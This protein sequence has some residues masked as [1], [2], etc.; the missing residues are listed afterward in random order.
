MAKTIWF[1]VTA[2]S[3]WNRPP[4]GSV[5][6]ELECARHLIKE[7]KSQ[8][9]FCRYDGIEDIHIEVSYEEVENLLLR[10]DTY[11]EGLPL[12]SSAGLVQKLK[13]FIKDMVGHLPQR[14]QRII[15]QSLGRCWRTAERSKRRL[16]RLL[17]RCP[18]FFRALPGSIEPKLQR[19]DVY[20]TLG[21]D[22]EVNIFPGMNAIKKKTGINVVGICYD[23]IPIKSPHLSPLK[24]SSH[25]FSDYIIDMARCA[26]KI[27][28]ISQN[29]LRDLGQFLSTENC[30][31]PPLEVIILGGDI[32][33]DVG[34]IGGKVRT[35]C[36]TPYILFVSTI[37][38][39]KNHEILYHAYR[40]FVEADRQD[41]PKLVFVGKP[42]WKVDDFLSDLRLDRSIDGLIIMLNHVNDS[43]LSCLYRHALF[44]VYPSLYEGWGLPVAESLAYGKF[45]IA[46]NTSSLPEVGGDFVEYLDPWDLPLWVERLAYYFDNLEAVREREVIIQSQYRPPTW[47]ETT[48]AVVNHALSLL[49]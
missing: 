46:S 24:D 14:P 38:R 34:T 42:G 48:R 27:L 41:L 31:C 17:G 23:V 10:L 35:I 2:I 13:S 4:I 18:I 33:A 29:T 22:W 30:H 28:C 37:E 39:R 9:R 1:D 26:D 20:I 44:T 12:R 49:I 15:I 45:C 47:M 40:R 5:R 16:I 7:F 3:N 11:V 25:R 6:V 19:G 8:I 36:R 43:E 32:K 21:L